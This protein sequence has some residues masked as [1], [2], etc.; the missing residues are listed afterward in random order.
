ML[1]VAADTRRNRAIQ[2][3]RA[4]HAGQLFG[5]KFAGLQIEAEAAVPP[6]AGTAQPPLPG[7]ACQKAA[8][9]DPV[10]SPGKPASQAIERQTLAVERPSHA[11]AQLEAA[12]DAI[13]LLR[14]G[15]DIGDQRQSG[16]RRPGDPGGR[17]EV[18]K[19]QPGL[20]KRP[21][22]KR[23]EQ[24]PA[25]AA[26]ARLGIDP[27]HDAIE[28]PV[29]GNG[30]ADGLLVEMAGN[31][32]LDLHRQRRRTAE[33]GRPGQVGGTK[34]RGKI[35]QAMDLP[36]AGKAGAQAVGGKRF[37]VFEP[38]N[39]DLF[40]V[41]RKRQAQAGWRRG[42]FSGSGQVDPDPLGPDQP[43]RQSPLEQGGG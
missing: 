26:H 2:A 18:G 3:G 30:Q 35:S 15:P 12:G 43:D 33:P 25:A 29:G 10:V 4:Q 41:D 7:E 20:G 21:T 28:R 5:I 40:D 36:V 16:K 39:G 1:A 9:E 17:V 32:R 11:V 38:G 24:Y 6:V 19:L 27:E 23:R 42:R 14:V 8:E 31:P 22:G 13:D 34:A 37:A